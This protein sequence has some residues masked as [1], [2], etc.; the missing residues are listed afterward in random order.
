MRV[1]IV[2]AFPEF[3]EDFLSTSMIGRAMKRGLLAVEVED[4]R[5]HG[6]GSYRQVDD[7]SFGGKGGMVLLP[8]VLKSALSSVEARRGP[9]Y[10]VSPS[11]QGDLLSQEVVETLAAQEHVILLC[12]HYEGLDERFVERYVDREISLGDFVLTGGEIPA[13]AIVDAMARLVPGVIGKESSVVEDSFY[14]GMLDNPHYTRPSEWEGEGVPEE[15]LSGNDAGIER[16]RR[17][18]AAKRT[19]ARRPDLIGRANIRPYLPKGVYVALVH[20]P[21]LDR[22]GGKSTAAVTGL[23]LSDMARSCRTFGVDRFLVTTPIASQ[24]ALVKTVMKHWTDG[25]GAEA[26]PDRGEALDLL[27]TFPSLERAVAW[28]SKR[29]KESPLIVGTT[30]KE[31]DGAFHWLE[32]KRRLLRE[33]KPVLFLFGTGSG[34]HEE[35]F[36]MCTAVLRPISGGE[37]VYRHLS[38]RAS[39]AVVLDRFFGWR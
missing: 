28:I 7:Y 16:W 13:M 3:F 23:D 21:V 27:K 9:G 20:S 36:G 25:W 6:L 4:L 29:E 8:D 17:A 15:L 39:A 5:K 24:R 19:L 38:V 18:S 34:L 14:R 30:A 32:M 26:N 31:R 10:R 33:E 11:P 37:G 2:T 12:G 1:T 35:V 22:Q